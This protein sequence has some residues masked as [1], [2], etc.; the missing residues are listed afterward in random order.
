MVPA[1]RAHARVARY[2][3]LTLPM[4]RKPGPILPPAG[5]AAYGRFRSAERRPAHRGGVPPAARFYAMDN[6]RY[7]CRSAWYVVISAWR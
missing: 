4:P 7:H 5:C 2:V 1:V 6:Q 3:P